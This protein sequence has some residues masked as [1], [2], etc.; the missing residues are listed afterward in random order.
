MVRVGTDINPCFIVRD[1]RR[2]RGSNVLNDRQF[3]GRVLR[4]CVR[5]KIGSA[6]K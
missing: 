4:V 1:S 6:L 2:S 5:K 3:P